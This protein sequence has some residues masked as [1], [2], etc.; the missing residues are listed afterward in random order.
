M[1]K[2]I[3]INSDGSS[4]STNT[5]L[6]KVISIVQDKHFIN[7]DELIKELTIDKIEY[8]RTCIAQIYVQS[9]QDLKDREIIDKYYTDLDEAL[10][11]RIIELGGVPIEKS[12]YW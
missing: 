11:L 4:C 2:T 1:D 8:G 5:M 7:N 6:D 3:K 9:A 12:F 10:K